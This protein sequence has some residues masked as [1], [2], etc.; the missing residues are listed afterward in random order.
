MKK[1]RGVQNKRLWC[2]ILVLVLLFGAMISTVFNSFAVTDEESE[3]PME[4]V[5]EPEEPT[6]AVEDPEDSTEIV[7]ES[8][9]SEET[10][11][12]DE[13]SEEPADV[14]ETTEKPEDIVEETD[15]NES[16][17]T[18]VQDAGNI[19]GFLWADGNGSLH[20]DWDGL[21]NG[22]E[23][24]LAEYTV[25]LYILGNLD[26][27]ITQTQTGS[28][29][30]Y[31][32]DGLEPGDY[33]VGLASDTVNGIE[34]LLPMSV[35]GESKFAIDWNTEPLTAYS[36]TIKIIEGEAVENI[37]AGMRLPMGIVP[38]TGIYL[39]I[40]DSTVIG[41]DL[42]L[43]DAFQRVNNTNTGTN[44]FTIVVGGN[45]GNANAFTVN[46]GKNVT[47]TSSD[48]GTFKLNRISVGTFGTVNGNLTLSNIILDGAWNGVNTGSGL[49]VN[50]TLTMN[51]GAVIRNCIASTNSNGRGG[52]VLVNNGATFTLDGGT[53]QGNVGSSSTNSSDFGYGGG[54]AV[55]AGG[56]FHMISGTI[57]GNVGN[58]GTGTGAGGGVIV[59]GN[60]GN[61]GNFIMDGGTISNNI[62]AT[63][64][65]IS[66]CYATG[67]GVYVTNGTFTMNGGEI[68]DNIGG[69]IRSGSGGGIYAL[70]GGVINIYNGSVIGG[71][72]AGIY[73]G[74]GGGVNLN[75]GTLNMYG[76][77]IINNNAPGS[78]GGIY[79]D[80]NSSIYPNAEINKYSNITVD[81]AATVSGNKSSKTYPNPQNYSAFTKFDGTLLDNDNIVYTPTIGKYFVVR[82]TGTAFIGSYDYLK[83][84]VAN[85]GTF[86]TS[87]SYT[88][89]ATQNDPDVT[90]GLTTAVIVTA[91]ASPAQSDKK[92]VITLTSDTSGTYSVNGG[93]YTLTQSQ[94]IRH[95]DV[96]GTLTITNIILDVNPTAGGGVYVGSTGTFNMGEGAVIQNCVKSQTNGAAVYIIGGTF[97]MEGGALL[98][99]SAL[100]TGG[101]VYM[102]SG[103]F[104][105]SGTALIQGNIGNTASGSPGNG[106]A[107]CLTV[108]AKFNM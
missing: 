5:G 83:D 91:D 51:T 90:Y 16:V 103:T 62:A 44:D 27:P 78:G 13:E 18:I 106:G 70:T 45:D 79:T 34:Y 58:N 74:N 10:T 86:A 85:C 59:E 36:E 53:I 9:D 61:I 69:A 55:E 87:G 33:V 95:F 11:G 43:Y 94:N 89:Y 68:T 48:D 26:V 6:E 20:S 40:Q 12:I 52:G 73:G 72:N 57:S 38:A 15:E 108:S 66:G 64:P 92:K 28:D 31:I 56:T 102:A 42:T 98:N 80:D 96:R 88:I 75:G 49:I 46:A 67:G 105:M 3:E 8:E 54:V 100:G 7:E 32:F 63:G 17:K 14:E 2:L 24:P 101:A 21:Y 81:S 76:G 99:N 71:N 65:T 30:T 84:A 39:V 82:D 50:G 4:I 77:K 107:I 29:G 97:N 104:N 35:T 19:S 41:G 22:S 60:I 23:Q 47:L 25:S 37:N 93:T 1:I